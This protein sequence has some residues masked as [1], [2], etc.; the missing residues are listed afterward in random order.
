[1]MITTSR[2]HA[3]KERLIEEI[4]AISP[5]SPRHREA[6]ITALREMT[7]DE[8]TAWK[9]DAEA[10]AASRPKPYSSEAA[11]ERALT[12][13]DKLADA[14]VEAGRIA[15]DGLA[16]RQATLKQ[17]AVRH[18]ITR[19]AIAAFKLGV[20]LTAS[21]AASVR[22]VE[23]QTSRGGQQ[24]GRSLWTPMA[25][26]IDPEVGLNFISNAEVDNRPKLKR[27]AL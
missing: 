19:T 13:L 27:S 25:H 9:V 14:L 7:I 22:T 24:L 16:A 1:M 11:R 23:V 26:G 3:Q 10:S 17:P 21:K 6:R 20:P 15:S 5:V 8:L 18:P 2:T 4:M 12:A